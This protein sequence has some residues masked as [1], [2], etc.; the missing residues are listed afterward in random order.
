M[1][2]RDTFVRSAYR[3]RL[4]NL[5]PKFQNFR[6]TG[7]SRKML[8]S[9]VLTFDE[10]EAIRL[11][12]YLGK[13]HLEASKLMKISRPTFTRLIDRARQ[14]TAQAIVE[15]MELIIEGGNVDFANALHRCRSCGEEEI[16][17]L[18]AENE[19]CNEYKDSCV[20]DICSIFV[21]TSD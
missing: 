4:V 17:P 11:A 13:G 18:N 7:I 6:P 8:K 14:K 20:R 3:K 5:P 1:Q 16:R 10:Y 15:G 21:P 19:K 12:D 9:V 2:L